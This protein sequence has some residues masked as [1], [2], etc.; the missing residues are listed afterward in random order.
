MASQP[1][2][3]FLD[4][5]SAGN[6]W[7]EGLAK[8]PW[9]HIMRAFASSTSSNLDD[10]RGRKIQWRMAVITAAFCNNESEFVGLANQDYRLVNDGDNGTKVRK[11][12]RNARTTCETILD[13][14]E[15]YKFGVLFV[16]AWA[17]NRRHLDGSLFGWYKGLA[18][19]GCLE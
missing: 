2:P 15:P 3:I 17:H 4:W 10:A 14:I 12:I 1:R 13:R 18:Y 9:L 7:A 5:S 11:T 19:C 16:D 6:G 8:S